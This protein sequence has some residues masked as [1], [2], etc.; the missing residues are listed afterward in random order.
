MSDHT[1]IRDVLT[2]LSDA[3][4]N[5]DAAAYAAL[6]T[7]DADYITFFGHHTEGRQAIEDSHRSL[8]A[9]P[10]KGSKMTAAGIVKIRFLSP[11][12]ALIITTGG[13]SLEG[14]D[15]PDPG[16]NSIVSFTAV[17]TPDGWRL[18]SF[19]NTRQTAV[20]GGGS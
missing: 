5:G 7:E 9:G 18:S 19:Q 11:D 8:F 2:R 20:P 4:N 3:W 14:E 15:K 12:A 16:R 17:R 1:A 6:F 10:L 13:T